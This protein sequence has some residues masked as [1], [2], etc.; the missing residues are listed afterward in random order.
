M[1]KVPG[2]KLCRTKGT[3]IWS[4]RVRRNPGVTSSR[5]I[6]SGQIGQRT[7]GGRVVTGASSLP[8]FRVSG[9]WARGGLELGVSATK[10]EWTCE[11]EP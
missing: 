9:I 5:E 6:G 2:V 4:I 3:S 10:P 8:G 7:V 1:L 11:G